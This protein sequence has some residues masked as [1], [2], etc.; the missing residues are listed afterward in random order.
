MILL[1]PS[2]GKAAGGDGSPLNFDL[3]SFGP[4]N[5][6][7]VRIAKSLAQLS[8]RPRVA[9]KLMGVKGTA[10]EK[11]M[12][13]NA[14]L[15][16]AP[17]LPAVERYSGVMYDSI[18]YQSLDRDAREAFDRTVI[19]MSGLFGMIRPLDMIPAYKL[20][21]GAPLLRR[22][23]CASIW[24]PLISKSLASAAENDVIWDLLPIEHSAAWHPSIVPYKTRFKIKFVESTADGRTK[25][26]SHLSKALKGEL[27][28]HLVCN[29]SAAGTPE[30]ALE[31]VAGFSHP[32]GYEFRPELISEGDRATELVFLKY[33]SA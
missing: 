4:L 22:R 32:E 9:K 25:T 19:I 16:E 6:T 13:D 26:V 29:S 33:Q 2:E 7:R 11:A 12:A 10:L 8:Q 23:T 3:L 15:V 14:C 18:D 27:V 5:H 24:K 20:K 28:R 31:L 1:P 21:M 30:S 17:T